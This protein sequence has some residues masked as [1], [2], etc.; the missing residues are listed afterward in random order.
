MMRIRFLPAFFTVLAIVF[1]IAVV[2]RIRSY[3]NDEPRSERQRRPAGSAGSAA[4][5]SPQSS[6]QQITATD[7]SA[8]PRSNEG[9]EI[10]EVP[11]GA[12]PEQSRPGLQVAG[13]APIATPIVRP[14]ATF[15]VGVNLASPA[16]EKAPAAEA[17]RRAEEPERKVSAEQ[18]GRSQRPA[19]S[20]SAGLDDPGEHREEADGTSDS[21]PPHLQAI[22]FAPPQIAD[23]EETMLIVHAADDLSGVRSI[24]GTILSPSGAVQGF[25]CQ[26]E[27]ESN[28]FS[29]RVRVPKDAA[30]G[31]WVVSY[32]NLLDNAS[33]AAALH[34]SR[35]GQA[36]TASFQVL[37]SRSDSDGPR[38]EA[39]W[40]DRR[41]MRGGEKNTLFVRA[42]D[43][44]TGISLISGIFQSPTR[45]ARVGFVCRGT[46]A[47]WTCEIAAPACADCGVWQ[48]EQLQLQDR[49][50]NM[51]TV[52]AGQNDLV[53]SVQID[54]SSDLCDSEPP[55]LE[56]I[57]LDRNTIHSDDGGIITLSARLAD[58]AC[59]VLSVSGQATG[60]VPASGTAPRLY[61]SFSVMESDP[62]AWTAKLNVPR[63]AA[64]GVWRITFMQVLDRGQNLKVYAGSDPLLA[65][66]SFQ[67]E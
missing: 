11:A 17:R 48:L 25:A 16:P 3:E 36:A 37:S 46:E 39:V 64:A 12:P 34:P 31:T 21:T 62:R 24:S 44:K 43:E 61:F 14:S 18:S 53:R 50:N 20:R 47:T 63:L 13:N 54:V 30:E 23:G 55:A 58:D 42:S 49:A 60:P 29:S 2:L 66:A 33:N 27:G 32:I 56:S 59:G 28:R 26:R 65:N 57:L 52:R 9:M 38:L 45:A 40:L 67:V 35:T 4:D 19:E 7:A 15:A 41:S 5:S 10:V 1:V 6:P 51:T 22:H 8:G